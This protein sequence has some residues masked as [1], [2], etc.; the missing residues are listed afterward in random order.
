MDARTKA[1]I[2]ARS[3]LS[4]TTQFTDA[5]RTANL[6]ETIT[7]IHAIP[8]I[9]CVEVTMSLTLGARETHY[10]LPATPT[11]HFQCQAHAGIN[12]VTRFQLVINW[13]PTSR[14]T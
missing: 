4:T 6:P 8:T 12:P 5:C 9:C 2:V 7:P 13:P 1:L 3:A 11:Q 10:G 14:L